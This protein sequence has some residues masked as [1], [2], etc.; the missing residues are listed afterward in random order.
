MTA[1]RSPAS[2]AVWTARLSLVRRVVEAYLRAHGRDLARQCCRRQAEDKPAAPCSTPSSRK[3]DRLEESMVRRRSGRGVTSA[4]PRSCCPGAAETACDRGAWATAG[5]RCSLRSACGRQSS[6]RVLVW[7]RFCGR[8]A[9][10]QG[11]VA[12]EGITGRHECRSL[13]RGR[14]RPCALEELKWRRLPTETGLH[15][16]SVRRE[17]AHEHLG[18]ELRRILSE[19]AQRVLARVAIW[20]TPH[21]YIVNMSTLL[22]HRHAVEHV[23]RFD[24][25]NLAHASSLS[26]ARL[27]VDE[28][29]ARVSPVASELL[30]FAPGAAALAAA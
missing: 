20:T 22:P 12:G 27:P 4:H 13:R 30:A 15:H 14:L 7:F 9:A 19:L 3:G 10:L 25:E 5:C 2:S 17:L 11:L 23:E 21:V 8:G 26:R 24:F 28:R 1:K 29:S 16:G 6:Q 18:M